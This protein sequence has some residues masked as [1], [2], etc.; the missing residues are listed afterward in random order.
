MKRDEPREQQIAENTQVPAELA[1]MLQEILSPIFQTLGEF[2]ANNTEA[3]NRMAA[4]QHIQS[5]RLEAL[6]KQ[7]RLNT[8]VTPTQV[9]Y[10]NEEIKKRAR[11]LLAKKGFEDDR[12]AVNA[13]SGKIRKAVL[14]RYGV[15]ALHE[16]PK[17]EYSV[18]LSMISSWSDALALLDIVK[19]AKKRKEAE[20][21]HG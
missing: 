15:A 7:I 5:D 13:L 1:V 18:T 19:E 20:D 8:L 9:K 16:I 4:Q 17:H 14:S 12:K 11:E 6:E 10:I 2:V 21:N 3:M